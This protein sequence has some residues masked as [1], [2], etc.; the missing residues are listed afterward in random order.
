MHVH[1]THTY[2]YICMHMYICIHNHIYIYTCIDVCVYVRICIHVGEHLYV[3]MHIHTSADLVGNTVGEG[4]LISTAA[5]TYLCRCN[6]C[7]FVV[8]HCFL[9]FFTSNVGCTL[10]A[11]CSTRCL[12]SS[13]AKALNM[14]CIGV[15]MQCKFELWFE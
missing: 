8:I 13:G 15:S 2:M 12:E 10:Q 4:L 1:G 7:A 6:L 11:S 3:Y 9:E 5:S 14:G